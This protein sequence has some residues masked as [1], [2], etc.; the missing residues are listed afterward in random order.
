MPQIENL[1]PLTELEAVNSMLS[2]IGEAPVPALTGTGLTDVTM[3]VNILREVTRDVLSEGWRFNTEYSVDLE[4]SGTVVLDGETLNVFTPPSGMLHY[5]D[6]TA[7]R[8]L[9]RSKVYQEGGE[10][11]L[12]FYDRDGNR[13][14]WEEAKL[15]LDKIISFVDFAW[16]PQ[17]ARSLLVQVAT[18]K[19]VKHAL[20]SDTIAAFSEADIAIARRRLV[21]AE[22]E[23][24]RR[25]LFNTPSVSAVL[26]GRR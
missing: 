12:V 23:R 14:G 17:V 10:D 20:G 4:P 3:A 2:A 5:D 7:T 8:A 25:N 18:N 1:A 9:R 19:F 13:E 16:I 26:G 15:T 6:A 11:V 22:G 21:R 24:R